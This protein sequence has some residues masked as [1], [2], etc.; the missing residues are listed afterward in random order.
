CSSTAV[1]A[2]C[3]AHNAIDPG[4]EGGF[5]SERVDLPHHAQNRVL[6][7]FLGIRA[8]AGD[9]HRQA[10]DAISVQS[11]QRLDGLGLLPAKRFYQIG[12]A[13]RAVSRVPERQL[14]HFDSLPGGMCSLLLGCIRSPYPDRLKERGKRHSPGEGCRGLAIAGG[15]VT[16]E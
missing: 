8:V 7:H 4:S 13:I 16:S 14:S 10:V 2:S 3:I 1:V 15:A 11:D 6:D 5:A 9:A 12:I